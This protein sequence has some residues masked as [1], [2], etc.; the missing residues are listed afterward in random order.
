MLTKRLSAFQFLQKY[1]IVEWVTT[2]QSIMIPDMAINAHE[3]SYQ[4]T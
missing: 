1:D 3:N 4:R 2:E